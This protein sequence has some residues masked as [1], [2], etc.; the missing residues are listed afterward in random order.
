MLRA[1][2]GVKTGGV[3]LAAFLALSI[4]LSGC[5]TAPTQA[6]VVNDVACAAA[7]AG[8]GISIA[9]G[10]GAAAA[11]GL[12]TSQGPAVVSACGAVIASLTAQVNAQVKAQKVAYA[13][14][15][16]TGAI[17]AHVVVPIN[18]K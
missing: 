16:P 2:R 11:L 13:K 5:S 14:A 9:S 18:V 7:L 15:H 10:V 1:I 8:I 3:F 12:I 6:D 4:G 17:G